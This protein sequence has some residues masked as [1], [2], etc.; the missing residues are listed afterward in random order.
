MNTELT[1]KVSTNNSVPSSGQNSMPQLRVAPPK[2]ASVVAS[3]DADMDR[4]V[5]MYSRE[6]LGG[7]GGHA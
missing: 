1:F 4:S 7:G 5:P 3:F 2:D 6:T